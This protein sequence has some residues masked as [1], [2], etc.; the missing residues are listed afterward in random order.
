MGKKILVVDDEPDFL[1]LIKMRLQASHY[2]VITAVNG[3]E[4]LT[5]IKSEQPNVVL[6]DIL[7][8]KLDGLQTLK[9]IRR[10][11]KKLPVFMLTAFSDERR[12]KSA[13]E[14]GASGFISKTSSFQ[15]EI[16]TIASA[17]RLADKYKGSN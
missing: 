3:K 6:L 17:L 16:E 5:K 12:F 11:D 8:P 9:K 10:K 4:A 1:E 2:D 7:M 15:K 13:R 14:L